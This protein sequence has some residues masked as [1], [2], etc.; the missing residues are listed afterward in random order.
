M[1]MNGWQIDEKDAIIA[2]QCET[3]DMNYSTNSGYPVRISEQ[4]RLAMGDALGLPET[5]QNEKCQA[6]FS[7]IHK[8]LVSS[9]GQSLIHGT[10]F[11]A[12]YIYRYI[13]L[14]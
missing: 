14:V 8:I 3:R 1:D 2:Q 5:H 10:C 7:A 11:L 12:M 9:N 6:R 4:T 13:D